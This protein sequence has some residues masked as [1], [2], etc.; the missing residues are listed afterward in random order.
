[1]VFGAI[2]IGCPINTLDP[3]FSKAQLMHMLK[4]TRPKVMICDV[5]CYD[6]VKECLADMENDSKFDILTIAGS[7]AGS[8]PIENLFATTDHEDQFL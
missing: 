1:M 4:T 5:I 7:K 6:L 3:S 8:E 2:A